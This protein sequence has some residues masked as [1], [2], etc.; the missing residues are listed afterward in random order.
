MKQIQTI[1]DCDGKYF[2]KYFRMISIC[3]SQYQT[4]NR[5]V[6]EIHTFSFMFCL[7]K[8]NLEVGLMYLL[9]LHDVGA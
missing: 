8:T 5:N 2:L 3:N 6:G 4:L 7:T 9:L 1:Y